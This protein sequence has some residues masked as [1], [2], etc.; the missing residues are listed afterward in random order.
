MDKD[1]GKIS[2]NATTDVIVRI[3]AFGGKPGVTI[4]EFVTG[5]DGGYSGFTKSGTR[6]PAEKFL[7]FR[8]VIN[9]IKL[10]DLN[11]V[12][13]KAPEKASEDAGEEVDY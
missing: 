3:D 6:I 13:E 7:E 8:E 10:D 9:S 12:A 11:A 2:K 4:R 1:I 5:K